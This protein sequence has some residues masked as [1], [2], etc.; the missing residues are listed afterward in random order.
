ML[1]RN[2]V[3]LPLKHFVLL[4]LICLKGKFVPDLSKEAQAVLELNLPVTEGQG[5]CL[6][7]FMHLTK[8]TDWTPI[9]FFDKAPTLIASV[10]L[11]SL[12]GPELNRNEYMPLDASPPASWLTPI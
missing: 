10:S 9:A 7:A 3:R 4:L 11:F 8:V 5:P 12:A 2:L 6:V 1:V